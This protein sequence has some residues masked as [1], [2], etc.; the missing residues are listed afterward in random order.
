MHQSKKH[1]ITLGGYPGSGK[2]TI[3]RLLAERLH[4]KT[5]STGDFT[6]ELAL[7][8]G[9]TLEAF[10]ELVATDKSLDLLID[11]ELIRIENEDDN[12]V[13][14]SHLAFHF[15]PK[16][17]SVYLDISLDTAAKRVFGDRDAVIRI[18]SG[19]TTTTLEEAKAK[20][21][22]RISNHRERY[23][24]HYAVDPYIPE[25]YDFV[26]SAEEETPEQITASILVAYEDWLTTER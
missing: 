13:I 5:F 8:R 20:T 12:Y 16:G 14:D 23:M 10:N 4:Y 15:V 24:R 11:E 17:F 19:D 1:V 21:W 22:K 3:K 7:K 26:V 18:Q 2:S 9:M 25:Q 6:R